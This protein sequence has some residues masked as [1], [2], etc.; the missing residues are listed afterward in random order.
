[1]II[2]IVLGVVAALLLLAVGVWILRKRVRARKARELE[3]Q[4]VQGKIEGRD[5]AEERGS[6]EV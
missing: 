3:E 1:M 5:S 2:G 6:R 4:R